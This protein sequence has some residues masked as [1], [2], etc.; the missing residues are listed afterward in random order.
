MRADQTKVRQSL[1]NLMSNACK[2]T[3]NGE[4]S[5]KVRRD[6]EGLSRLRCGTRVWG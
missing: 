6:A 2:F 3:S 1:F 4:V 5:L